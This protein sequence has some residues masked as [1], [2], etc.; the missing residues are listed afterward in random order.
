MEDTASFSLVP[1]PLGGV[2][3]VKPGTKRILSGMVAEV[4]KLAKREQNNVALRKFRI[5]AFEWCEPDYRQIL[6]WAEALKIEPERIVQSI[7]DE[8]S[9][10]MEDDGQQRLLFPF[11]EGLPYADGR[12]LQINWDFDLLPLCKFDWLE[13]LRITHI[14]F[15]VAAQFLFCKSSD[16]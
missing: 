1:S 3:K 4:V 7:F 2:E 14:R 5:G 15:L 11:W 13:G 10:Y 8:R 6:V 12:L 9:L 16:H